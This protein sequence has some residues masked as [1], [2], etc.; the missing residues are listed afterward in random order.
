[1]KRII[2]FVLVFVLA[3]TTAFGYT[4][5]TGSGTV[6][7]P[8][9]IA[10]IDDLNAISASTTLWNKHFIQTDNI[11]AISTAV[12]AGFLPIG[13]SSKKFTGSYNGD[14]YTI[15]NLHIDRPTMNYVALFGWTTGATIS[16][17]GLVDNVII[18]NG[19]VGSIAGYLFENSTIEN[20][21]ATGSV[22]GSYMFVGGLAGYVYG[23]TINNSYAIG[24]TKGTGLD[25]NQV[26]GIA[27]SVAASAANPAIINNC[28]A[29]GSVR[30]TEFVGGLI[31]YVTNSTINSSYATGPVR[32]TS[33]LG[34][35]V[36]YSFGSTYND[37][38]WDKDTTGQLFS[39]GGEGKDT[40]DMKDITTYA[41]WDITDQ[42]E[43]IT[44]M[45]KIT[46]KN[47]GYP[48][49]TWAEVNNAT[50]PVTLASFTAIQTSNNLAQISWVTA[51]ESGVLG[52]DIYRAETNEQATAIRITAT[53]I[54][55]LNAANG[56]SYSHIDNEVEFD[57]TYYYW[58]QTNDFN[59][60]SEM[61]GPVTI[62]ISTDE[63]HE[64]EELLLG[65][66]LLGNYPN[67][68]NPSTTISY[69]VAK[70][71]VVTI[72]VYNL[73]GQLVRK[74]LDKNVDEVNVKHSVVWNGNDSNGRSVSSGTYFTVME[75]GNKRFTQKIVLM[76]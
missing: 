22:T 52:Y 55:A 13:K 27:G 31:G 33:G 30:G 54:E 72:N 62:R 8:Y 50:L 32:G 38:F 58:L 11:D 24:A 2:L 53:M 29:R 63:D 6:G 25:A 45:W 12:G 46:E 60:I 61:V 65:T 5:T 23:S 20:C 28:Y 44:H 21:Y 70:P 66:N 34:G 7:D 39:A 56:A 16:N 59:G 49:L 71:Q 64:I 37:S 3:T 68:F 67:P 1:M 41:N 40:A 48:Y 42:V 10:N 47:M 26:G 35:L 74:V 9:G 51:S 57:V 14:N 4:F 75:A 18:G 69:S 36:G 73:K 15:S 76:K 43:D 17:L 19:M